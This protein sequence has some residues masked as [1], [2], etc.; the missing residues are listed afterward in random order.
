[1]NPTAQLELV[2]RLVA[3]MQEAEGTPGVEPLSAAWMAM[4]VFGGH[5]AA[6]VVRNYSDV[7]SASSRR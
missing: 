1:M 5:I 4:Q 6:D 2:A 7:S 3:T